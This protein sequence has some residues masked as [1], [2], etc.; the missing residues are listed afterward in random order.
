M[1]QS[2]ATLPLIF[3]CIIDNLTPLK[4]SFSLHISCV[5]L[6]SRLNSWQCQLTRRCLAADT[7]QQLLKLWQLVFAALNSWKSSSIC[8]QMPR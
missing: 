2:C 4:A 6:N 3:V 8:Y 7:S 1:V 5:E